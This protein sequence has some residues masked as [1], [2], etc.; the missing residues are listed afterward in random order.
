MPCCSFSMGLEEGKKVVSEGCAGGSWKW[1][2]R[3]RNSN[4]ICKLGGSTL[5]P[6]GTQIAWRGLLPVMDSLLK[7]TT[8]VPSYCKERSQSPAILGFRHHMLLIIV[9]DRG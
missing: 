8:L 4:R 2:G 7:P 5:L 9:G 3:D 6:A 1:R